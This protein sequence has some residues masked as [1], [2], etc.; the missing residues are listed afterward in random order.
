VKLGAY[1]GGNVGRGDLLPDELVPVDVGK[2]GMG[3]QCVVRARREQESS[4][5]TGGNGG[6]RSTHP[7]GDGIGK[8]LLGV[9]AQQLWFGRVVCV[10]CVS[11]GSYTPA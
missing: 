6:R 1:H 7:D 4:T 8:P 10:V 5:L 11:K 2:V 9:T 3:L